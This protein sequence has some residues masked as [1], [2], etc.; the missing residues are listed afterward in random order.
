MSLSDV[1]LW[2]L[3]RGKYPS[4]YKFLI[5]VFLL[6]TLSGGMLSC[7]RPPDR[8]LFDRFIH[9]SGR[10]KTTREEQVVM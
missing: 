6:F 2:C 7:P 3:G 10:Q 5:R 8:E 9:H 1:R 4:G